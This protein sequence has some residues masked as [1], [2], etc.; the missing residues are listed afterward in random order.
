MKFGMNKSCDGKGAR[1][2]ADTLNTAAAHWSVERSFQN[3][4]LL[5]PTQISPPRRVSL[6]FSI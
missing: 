5:I 1:S 2:L 4:R 3:R 6:F